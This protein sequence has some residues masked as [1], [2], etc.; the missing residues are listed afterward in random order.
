MAFAVGNRCAAA[1]PVGAASNFFDLSQAAFGTVVSG[2]AN[3]VV[4]WDNGL[5]STQPQDALD[6]LV[7]SA[8]IV[9][10]VV[11]PVFT[12][13]APPASD[14][15]DAIVL[16]EYQRILNGSGT[17]KGTFLLMRIIK[18]GVLWEGLA[19]DFETVPDR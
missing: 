1:K 8:G 15:S 7:P 13:G 19:S 12:G 9:P 18:T 16:A 4:Q 5:F 3:P 6:E 17:N 10:R 2:G 14:A 11:R